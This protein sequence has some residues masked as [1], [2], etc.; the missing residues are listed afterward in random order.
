[1]DS[2]RYDPIRTMAKMTDEVIVA[3]SGGKDSIV[4][5]DMCMRYFKRVVPFFMYYVPRLSFQERQLQ[6]YEQKYGIQIER[7]PHFEL[8]SLLHCGAFRNE[9]LDVPI[10]GLTDI[11]EWMRNK[12]G[13]YW[14]AAGERS[15][16]SVIRGAMIK[17]S[18]SIDAVRGRFYPVAWWT[19]QE[20]LQYIKLK[21]L[22][23]AA[24]SRRLGTSFD[25]VTT[26]S[27]M[28]LKEHFPTD[29]EKALRLFPL[30]EGAIMRYQVY[31]KE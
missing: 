16:D 3:F 14:V 8:S 6:W 19:K 13:I 1:M 26:H 27:L 5:L 25:G 17:K 22:Y 9:D 10:V 21:K 2:S 18:G 28:M 7:L 4:V 29:Y 30:C 11:Y 24:D 23:L 20:I 31:G 12:Y 15:A